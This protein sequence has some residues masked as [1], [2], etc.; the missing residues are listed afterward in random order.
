M[1]DRR[2]FTLVEAMLVMALIGILSGIGGV[3]LLS[4]LPNYRVNGATRQLVMDFRLAKTLA[5]E[6]GDEAYVVFDVAQ[7][8]YRVVRDSNQNGSYDAGS[9]LVL[10][11]IRLPDTHRGVEFYTHPGASGAVTF[12]G[13]VAIFKP[14]GTANG[15]TV[16]LRPAQDA[17][18]RVDRQRRITVINT[19]RAKATRWNGSD[20][21]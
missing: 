21:V 4:Q 12:S 18:V 8:A 7:N 9:D 3:Y 16:Y 10:K 19:A 6:T 20:W 13:D 5:V 17:G 11:T 1:A 2:G 15:G 14:R